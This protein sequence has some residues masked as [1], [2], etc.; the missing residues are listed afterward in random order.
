MSGLPEYLVSAYA[1]PITRASLAVITLLFV[2]WCVRHLLLKVGRERSRFA[3]AASIIEGRLEEVAAGQAR[4]GEPIP[5]AILFSSNKT[6]Q[7]LWDRFVASWTASVDFGERNEGSVDVAGYFTVDRTIGNDSYL[8]KLE[9]IPGRLLTLGILGTFIGLAKGLPT[10]VDPEALIGEASTLIGGLRTAFL[11]SIVGIIYSLAFLVFEK[12][13]V[14]SAL[15]ELHRFHAVVGQYY[16]VVAPELALTRIAR[17]AAQQSDSLRALEND[18]AATLSESFGGAVEQHLVP[19]IEEMRAAVSKA[20]DATAQVQIE[21]IQKIVNKFM[22]GMDEQLGG[23]FNK[24][25]ETIDTASVN[26]GS[27]ADRL[28][29][30]AESQAEIMERTS[31]TAK[32]LETQLPHLL[33][34]GSQLDK[35]SAQFGG[36][37]ERVS[38]LNASLGTGTQQLIEAQKESEARFREILERLDASAALV[39]STAEAQRQSQEKMEA[40]YATALASF[41]KGLRDGLIQSLTAFDST[42]GDILERFSGTIADMKE[43]Y[44]SLNRHSQNLK[45]SVETAAKQIAENMANAGTEATAAHE[46]IRELS[47]SYVKTLEQGL[48]ESNA[49]VNG[50]QQSAGD[51]AASLKS[52]KESAVVIAARAEEDALGDRRS[53]WGIFRGGR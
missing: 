38:E 6:Y 8:R 2:W 44:D 33:K 47:D 51:I 43:Q 26:L 24:L 50:L 25:G 21:G 39:R 11:T 5:G 16:P 49:A 22:E 23:S 12:A 3:M 13:L 40:A 32:V 42:L 45:E 31:E 15:S 41:E 7:D 4:L 48:A 34:F 20:T 19:L 27:L 9:S 17:S 36:V 35:A 29:R 28:G 14:G 18:L 52:L 53:G 37:V 10:A 46:R 30:A 1:S